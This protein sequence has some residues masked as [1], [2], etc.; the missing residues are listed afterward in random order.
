MQRT[1]LSDVLYW[2]GM[3]FAGFVTSALAPRANV[4]LATFLAL[5]A[6][7]LL[8]LNHLLSPM[9]GVHVDLPGFN[10]ALLLVIVGFPMALLFCGIGGLLGKKIGRSNGPRF[11][12]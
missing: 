10:G 3:T 4:R 1:L 6:T 5:P 2:L 8:V 9:L 12:R 7:T 11:V